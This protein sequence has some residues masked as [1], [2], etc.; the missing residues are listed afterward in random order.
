VTYGAQDGGQEPRH[1][2]DT[3]HV[4]SRSASDDDQQPLEVGL[5]P[6]KVKL[7]ISSSACI[8]SAYVT[9]VAGCLC[10]SFRLDC[11]YSLFIF[12]VDEG[13]VH[14][15]VRMTLGKDYFGFL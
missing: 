13:V 1:N 9:H 12:V 15:A 2:T 10:R 7:A 6:R 4:G 8:Q 5:C 14:I 11:R 3:I